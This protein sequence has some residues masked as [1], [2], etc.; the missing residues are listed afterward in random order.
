MVWTQGQ[1][2]PTTKGHT[3][4]IVEDIIEAVSAP[5]RREHKPRSAFGLE[6]VSRTEYTTT[7]GAGGIE[8]HG[9]EWFAW[10]CESTA[11]PMS[12]KDAAKFAKRGH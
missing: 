2:G 7:D 1:D 5:T 6:Y 8:Q 4:N 3:M 10:H 11:G 9:G 12:M